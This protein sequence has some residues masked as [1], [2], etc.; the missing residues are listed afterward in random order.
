MGDMPR[1][2]KLTDLSAIDFSDIPDVRNLVRQR[3]RQMFG[4]QNDGYIDDYL[5]SIKQ[6]FAGRHPDYQAVDTAYHDLTHTLQATLCLVELLYRR[7]K[8]DADPSVN[9]HSLFSAGS[10]VALR[11]DLCLRR[12]AR[13]P[14]RVRPVGSSVTSRLVMTRH[15]LWQHQTDR[16]RWS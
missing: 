13:P 11:F 16:S 2:S 7:H 10:I 6:L 8:T 14:R 4:I 9:K 1:F 12:A 15:L 5:D 3:S